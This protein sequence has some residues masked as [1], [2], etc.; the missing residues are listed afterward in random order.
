MQ[1]ISSFSLSN[2]CEAILNNCFVMASS[3]FPFAS[4]TNNLA[5]NRCWLCE[6]TFPRGTTKKVFQ[7]QN[8]LEYFDR[9]LKD[10]TSLAAASSGAAEE[11]EE[12]KPTVA[13]V[14]EFKTQNMSNCYAYYKNSVQINGGIEVLVKELRDRDLDLWMSGL[15][16][17]LQV[18]TCGADA[19][20]FIAPSKTSHPASKKSSGFGAGLNLPA[21]IT[22]ANKDCPPDC[23]CDNP[24]AFLS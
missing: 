14:S 20:L 11:M 19:D 7:V 5:M 22:F 18:E 15:I 2:I 13:L 23:G 10:E 21:G 8:L 1:A 24:W 3:S 16:C 4:I 9:R 6:Q 12:N 17:G